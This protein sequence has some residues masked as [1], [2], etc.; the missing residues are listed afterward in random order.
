MRSSIALLAL[1]GAACAVPFVNTIKKRQTLSSFTDVDILNY[2]LTLE[3]LEDK[4]Y[5]EALALFSEADFA[6]AGLDSTFYAN[7]KETSFDEVTHVAF[8]TGRI[9]AA[10]AKAVKE[11]TYAFGL[12]SVATFLATASIFEG[13]GVAAYLGAAPQ[14]V[15]KTYLVYAG[16]VLSV[17]SR[18]S[19]Y[20]RQF[21]MPFFSTTAANLASGNALKQS[22]FPQPFEVPLT[23]NEVFTLA[24]P[25]ITSCPSDNPTIPVR[26][27][28]QLA[29]TST[30]N[31][32]TGSQITVSTPGYVLAP[33][34]SRAK[35]YASFASATGPIFAPLTPASNGL[36]YLV[37]IPEGVF[38]QN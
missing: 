37:T 13:I 38:G 24:S 10:G 15:D 7:L 4:F 14:I 8:L 34:D 22:P 27:Y 12:D 19:S 21:T 29:V 26:A 33:A 30:G 1:A 5:R 17:E 16:A 18:H 31:M 36:D 25:F 28:P 2:A 20:L 11:C 3:H 35:I 23:P 32:T 6:A 9:E